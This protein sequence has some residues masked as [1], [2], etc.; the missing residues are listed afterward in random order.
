MKV[1]SQRLRNIK[2]VSPR[3]EVQERHKAPSGHDRRRNPLAS[4]TFT[5]SSCVGQTEMNEAHQ[6]AL[7]MFVLACTAMT[8]VAGQLYMEQ[9]MDAKTSAPRHLRTV[10]LGASPPAEARSGTRP[11]LVMLTRP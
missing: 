11:N 6:L 9:S 5:I 4:A 3:S 1:F 10:S 2:V 7:A 8:L